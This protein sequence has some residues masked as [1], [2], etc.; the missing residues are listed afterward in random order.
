MVK[1]ITGPV[2]GMVTKNSVRILVEFDS[3][4]HIDIIATEKMT[5]ELTQS[6]VSR[7]F[8]ANRAKA[9][10]VCGLKEKTEY[11]FSFR[12][13]QD[14]AHEEENDVANIEESI[15]SLITQKTAIEEAHTYKARAITL[16]PHLQTIRAVIVSGNTAK[17]GPDLFN[18]I[19]DKISKNPM[20]PLDAIFHVGGQIDGD[21]A[22]IEAK[23]LLS[24][25][26][27]QDSL[28][29]AYRRHYRAA[30]NHKPLR[31]LMGKYGNFF[32][33]SIKDIG[34]QDGGEDD[35]V[36]NNAAKRAYQEYQ[37]QLWCST[38][39]AHTEHDGHAQLFGDHLGILFLDQ[40][41]P[42]LSSDASSTNYLSQSQLDQIESLFQPKAAIDIYDDTIKVDSDDP[43]GLFH[44]IKGLVVVSNEP[45]L[46]SG[47]HYSF[48]SPHTQ[49]WASGQS[50]D[51]RDAFLD[52]CYNFK[53]Q[54]DKNQV[55]IVTGN[56]MGGAGHSILKKSSVELDQF[57]TSTVNPLQLDSRGAKSQIEG[58]GT[59][60]GIKYTHFDW[61]T[62]E[63]SFGVVDVLH[64]ISNSRPMFEHFIIR[65]STTTTDPKKSPRPNTSWQFDEEQEKSGCCSVM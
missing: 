35:Q 37:K 3:N 46:L 59:S 57:V 8:F 44:K 40:L 15:R 16:G 13:N 43:V 11:I 38:P 55:L 60:A 19:E 22:R 51:Q 27:S 53:K 32:L 4:V 25:G 17:D 10:T 62:D 41:F 52:K 58:E 39:F 2:V 65:K 36:L 23:K 31:N 5:P 9:V 24:E 50:L 63:Q 56:S 26:Q 33:P 49:T 45:L 6:T 18:V 42:L 14:E 7:K 29:E 47:S 30:Y 64:A 61:I 12:T 54:S 20:K 28:C 34:K 1:I 21:V 48:T